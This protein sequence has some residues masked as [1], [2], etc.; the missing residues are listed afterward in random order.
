MEFEYQNFFSNPVLMLAIIICLDLIFGD[1]I[2]YFHPVRIIGRMQIVI[3]YQLRLMGFYGKFGGIILVAIIVV[4]VLLFFVMV[5]HFLALL[6]WSLA[7][8][9]SIYLGWSLIALRDLLDHS[10]E[11]AKAIESRNL[12]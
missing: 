11:V 7:W 3:E 10:I 2:Y 1:P 6:H 4:S 5:D 12:K 9:W 8:C